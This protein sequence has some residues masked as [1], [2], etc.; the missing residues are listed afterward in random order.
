MR[1]LKTKEYKLI[2]TNEVPSP[3]PQYAIL[4]HTW[5]SPR[6]EITYQDFKRRKDDIDYGLYK[7]KG[8]TK[9]KKYCDRA[10]KDGWDWA[11]MDTC[12]ID[13]TNPADTQEA[14]NAMFRWYQNAGICYAYLEDVDANEASGTDTGFPLNWDLDN[15]ASKDN[16]ADSDSSIH[17]ALGPPL[18]KAKWFTRGW[19]LQ[20]LLAPPYLVFVDRAWRRIGTRESWAKEIKTAS[21]IEARYLT[22]FSPTDFVSCSI[23]KRLSWASRRETTI[24]EDETYSLLGLFGISLPL[25][26]GEGRWRAFNRLQREL[27]IVYNDDS[28]F[29]WKAVPSSNLHLGSQWKDSDLRSGILAPS[30]R[31]YWDASDINAFGLFGYSFN[32]T[33]R[34]LE[35]NAKR[36]KCRKD[37]TKFCISLA[38]GLEASN[39]ISIPLKLT[40]GFYDR[41]H[42]ERLDNTENIDENWLEERGTGP[43]I[44]R[45][46]NHSKLNTSSLFALDYP[47]Q[48]TVGGKYF[49]EFEEGNAIYKP[50]LRLLNDS[51]SPPEQVGKDEIIT[52]PNY[53]IFINIEL[54]GKTLKSYFDVVINLGKNGFPSVGI[55]S[56]VQENRER[57]GDPLEE[58]VSN[59]YE[60]FAEHLHYSISNTPAY[61]VIAVEE[62]EDLTIGISLLPRPPI[63]GEAS[64]PSH[65]AKRRE[66]VVKITVKEGQQSGK[67]VSDR[68]KRRRMN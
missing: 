57:L 19:T 6:D 9:F 26:Y 21:S 41:I 3:F 22:D 20:E 55:Y 45:S 38:C 63:R 47:R 50:K 28:I 8:W 59:T 53:I 31:E 48:I 13:K 17:K 25:I 58:E 18:I 60:H 42:V 52:K 5:I 36:W 49:I 46:S 7:Q 4:S 56:R 16:I 40:D 67:G 27:I 66:Y 11:W 61:R 35:I 64:Q 12:C 44:I 34:G 29:A 10:A 2:E 32:L 65:N 15:I 30:I 1:L 62:S 24:E 51:F 68:S 37:P 14:I 23:A 33:N 43:T 54:Q 39:R